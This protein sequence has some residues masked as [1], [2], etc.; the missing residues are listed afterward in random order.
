MT[1]RRWL[2]VILMAVL[3]FSLRAEVQDSPDKVTLTLLEVKTGDQALSEEPASKIRARP[4]TRVLAELNCDLKDDEGVARA[5]EDREFPIDSTVQEDGRVVSQKSAKEFVGTELRLSRGLAKLDVSFHH[6]LKPPEML[7]HNY[8]L[9]ASEK[10]VYPGAKHH[11]DEWKDES[12]LIAPGAI[13]CLGVRELPDTKA[14]VH[15]AFVR[16]RPLP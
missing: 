5:G 14:K 6:D 3:A 10:E 15:I 11:F 2:L 12:L 1:L 8:D 7:R 9:A 13:H 16:V 4:Q